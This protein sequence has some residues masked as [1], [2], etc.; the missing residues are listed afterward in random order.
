MKNDLHK[1]LPEHFQKKTMRHWFR[2][3]NEHE[4]KTKSIEFNI[5]NFY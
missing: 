3:Y 1:V 2:Q 5:M 4:L